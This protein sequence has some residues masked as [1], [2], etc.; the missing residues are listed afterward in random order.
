MAA[1]VELDHDPPGREPAPVDATVHPPGESNGVDVGR[2]GFGEHPAHRPLTQRHDHRLQILPSRRELVLAA[3]T[4]GGGA[5]LEHPLALEVA[6]ALGEQGAGDA[7]EPPLDVVEA[8]AP[9][10]HLAQDERRPPVG[11]HL[12]AQRHGAVLPVVLHG[13]TVQISY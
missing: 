6:E 13:H 10:H 5:S 8:R 3:P 7:G 2:F 12:A 11:E 4:S 9:E 1:V